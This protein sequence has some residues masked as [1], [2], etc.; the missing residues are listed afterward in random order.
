MEEVLPPRRNPKRSCRR[1]Y[2]VLVQCIGNINQINENG[3][4]V[5]C[6][7]PR[8]PLREVLEKYCREKGS[9]NGIG[10]HK[11]YI[12]IKGVDVDAMF[13]KKLIK[14]DD[15]PAGKEILDGE[16]IYAKFGVP[17]WW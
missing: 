5:V 17:V 12:D 14:P 11:F 10:S 15:T 6:V 1:I 8:V 9:K 7:N 4:K 16:R 13:T 3:T 2:L